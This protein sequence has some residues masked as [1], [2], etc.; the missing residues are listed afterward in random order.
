MFEFKDA[1]KGGGGD[2][3]RVLHSWKYFSLLSHSSGHKNHCIE[4]LNLL[5]QYYYTLHPHSRCYG[6][7]LLY[8]WKDWE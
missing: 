3:R 6:D 5:A 4:A 2:G 7:D 8:S 1:I